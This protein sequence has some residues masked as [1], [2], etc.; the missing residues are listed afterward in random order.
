MAG[1]SFSYRQIDPAADVDLGILPNL[2]AFYDA[3]GTIASDWEVRRSGGERETLDIEGFTAWNQRQQAAKTA[4]AGRQEGSCDSR[5]GWEYLVRESMPNSAV[6]WALFFG[7][8]I[9]YS[10]RLLDNFLDAIALVVVQ[11]F[12]WQGRY[13]RERGGAEGPARLKARDGATDARFVHFRL[14]E[15]LAGGLAS[16]VQTRDAGTSTE[17]HVYSHW[18]F[19]SA[20]G[21]LAVQGASGTFAG[22][23]ASARAAAASDDDNFAA[24][25]NRTLG[26][27]Q[28][29]DYNIYITVTRVGNPLT[30]A[31]TGFVKDVLRYFLDRTS[32]AYGHACQPM[33]NQGRWM[34]NVG[35]H[36]NEGRYNSNL[37]RPCC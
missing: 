11:G 19:D 5:T 35:V 33:H 24:M 4:L 6:R 25:G 18:L 2:E 36:I 3:L 22:D 13:A 16:G 12:D 14:E 27:R 9:Y 30:I 26:A 21:E 29:D 7:V 32:Q 1:A 8:L 37:P 20:A 28:T 34:T 17:M 31:S 10:P 15:P 23:S